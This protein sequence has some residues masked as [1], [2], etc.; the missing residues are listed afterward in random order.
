MVGQ[1]FPAYGQDSGIMQMP[2]KPGLSSRRSFK[3][4][5]NTL[6]GDNEVK[7]TS[8][9]HLGD[10]LGSPDY[11]SQYASEKVQQW[12]KELKLLSEI[13]ITQPHAAFAANT[14]GPASKWSYLCRTSPFVSPHLKLLED[15][16]RTEFIPN[17]T[18]AHHQ[19]ML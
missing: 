4:K 9:G 13:A 7:I 5:S 10:P 14:H 8:E 3:Q 11:V 2:L 19:M 16:L 1:D 12:S 15:V 18:A 6:F 17:L